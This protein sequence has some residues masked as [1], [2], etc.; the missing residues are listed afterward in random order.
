[1]LLYYWELWK[2]ILFTFKKGDEKIDFDLGTNNSIFDV[3]YDSSGGSRGRK[4]FPPPEKN[5]MY[6]RKESF[7]SFPSKMRTFSKILMCMR[8][9]SFENFRSPPSLQNGA[10]DPPLYG[11][12]LFLQKLLSAF[13]LFWKSLVVLQFYNSTVSIYQPSL[14]VALSSGESEI[15]FRWQPF[16]Q[17]FPTVFYWNWFTNITRA[18]FDLIKYVLSAHLGR[19]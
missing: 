6:K 13:S 5:D 19:I 14:T 2:R 10:L 18:M 8:K 11:S 4:N 7:R 3:F 1:M 12:K 9:I 15:P 16:S 17:I